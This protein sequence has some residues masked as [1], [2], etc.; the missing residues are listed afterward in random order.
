MRSAQLLVFG[1]LALGACDDDPLV[2]STP[3]EPAPPA[4][5]I[6][7]FIQV[8]NDSAQPGNQVRVWVKVQIGG[9]TDARLGSYTGRLRFDPAGLR[10]EQGH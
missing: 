9:K 7:A 6:Q 3:G 1:A 4:Q 8:D 10:F 2:S 5:G